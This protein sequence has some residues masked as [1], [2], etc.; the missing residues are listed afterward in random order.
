MLI[1]EGSYG[2][3]TEN[4]YNQNE[5]VKEYKDF[6]IFMRELFYLSFLKIVH[7]FVKL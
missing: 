1:G 7:I 2:I 6:D 3:V 5:V 4:F